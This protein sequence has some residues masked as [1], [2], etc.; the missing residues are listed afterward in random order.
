MVLL[1]FRPLLTLLQN[2][3]LPTMPPTTIIF[4]KTRTKMDPVATIIETIIEMVDIEGE[5]KHVADSVVE[6]HAARYVGYLDI[7]L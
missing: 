5:E 2:K 6:T 4:V 3:N 7:Q 1:F